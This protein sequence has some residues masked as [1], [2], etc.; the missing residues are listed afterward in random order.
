[1]T[2]GG[3]DGGA[4]G[5]L[6]R[7]GGRMTGG[8]GGAGGGGAARRPTARGG[9]GLELHFQGAALFGTGAGHL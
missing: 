7:I 2:A 1:M 5:G 3:V 4:T 6:G 9:G 8:G